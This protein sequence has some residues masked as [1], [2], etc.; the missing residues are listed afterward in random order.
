MATLQ[1]E[2]V[3][4]D[5][6]VLS[7]EVE[8]VGAPGY[9]GEFGIL[10]NHIPFLTALQVGN[11]YYKDGGKTFYVFVAGGF[12]EVSDNKVTIMAEVAEMATEIDADRARKARERAEQRMAQQQENMESA[13][14][15]AALARSLAR[16]SCRDRAQAA[17]TCS[18]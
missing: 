4:P 14:M 11:L 1:L 3:T 8:Y 16:I 2:I 7:E 12:A 15:Q 5:R 10:P 13:R 17:G 6:L 9:E 18:N